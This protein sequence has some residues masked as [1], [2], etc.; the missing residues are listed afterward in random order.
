[1]RCCLLIHSEGKHADLQV[2]FAFRGSHSEILRL[3]LTANTNV[4]TQLWFGVLAI[5]LPD[6]LSLPLWLE[7]GQLAGGQ[8]YS[9]PSLESELEEGFQQ[10]VSQAG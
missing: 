8:S 2:L 10:D 1:M 6:R 9:K 5:S 7:K 4:V 3:W